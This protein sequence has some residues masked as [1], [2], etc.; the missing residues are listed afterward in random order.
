VYCV[1]G[2]FFELLKLKLNLNSYRTLVQ[3]LKERRGL[4]SSLAPQATIVIR[5]G[6]AA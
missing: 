3:E 6:E 5:E 1:L 4:Q 2:D